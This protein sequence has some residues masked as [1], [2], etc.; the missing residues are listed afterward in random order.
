MAPQPG[1]AAAMAPQPGEGGGGGGG[2]DELGEAGDGDGDEEEYEEEYEEE[3]EWFSQARPAAARRAV[4][5][6]A[7]SLEGFSGGADALYL[8]YATAERAAA[9]EAIARSAARGAKPGQTDEPRG[10]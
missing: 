8:E 5:S 7:S 9:S 10:D 6:A 4:R 2:E 1:E 3:D